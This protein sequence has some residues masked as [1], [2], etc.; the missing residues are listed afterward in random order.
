M[1]HRI[2]NCKGEGVMSRKTLMTVFM[3]LVVLMVGCGKGEDL[4]GKWVCSDEGISTTLELFS[5]GTGT[6]IQG[7]DSYS[8]SWIAENG[9]LKIS[10]SLGF[11]GEYAES[12]S[13]EQ[14]ENE[15]TFT[16]DDDSVEHYTRE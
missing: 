3:M 12:A 11:L 8:I 2:K 4:T 7:E 9:R 13:Y 5:D 6:L 10:A 14:K 1:R 16:Y 15:L